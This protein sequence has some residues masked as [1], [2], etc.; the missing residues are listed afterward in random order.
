M[1]QFIGS[2]SLPV[3]DFDEA[4]DFYTRKLGFSLVQ[5]RSLRDGR[6]WV[7]V[8]PPG[9]SEAMVQL[10]RPTDPESG[11]SGSAGIASAASATEPAARRGAFASKLGIALHTDDF[12]RDYRQMRTQ[13]VQ[14]EEEPREEAY[15]TVAGFEDPYGN[16]WNLTE[17]RR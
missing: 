15:S 17:I 5:D 8:S 7:Y 4:I 1:K 2:V 10:L 3:D 16:R 11:L 13:G 12:W 6:R 14:F 9:A